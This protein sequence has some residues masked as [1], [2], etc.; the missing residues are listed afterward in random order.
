MKRVSENSRIDDLMVDVIDYAFTEWL[1]RQNLFAAFKTNYEA[2]LPFH[3]A[4]HDRLRS[5]I[6]HCIHHSALGVSDLVCS[7]FLFNS[8]PEGFAFWS[9]KSTDWKR[10]CAKF[11]TKF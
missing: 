7:A 3:V 11:Q 6:R 8:T 9:K 10:L 4:F 2:T 1:V 5:F